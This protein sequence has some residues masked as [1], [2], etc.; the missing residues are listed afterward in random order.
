MPLVDNIVSNIMY[1]N[2]VNAV[3]KLQGFALNKEQLDNID[4]ILKAITKNGVKRKR[5]IAYIFATIFHESARK[6]I[7]NGKKV[8]RRIVCVEEIGKGKG[9][10][11]G[12]K[13]K[14]SGE[15]YTTPDKLYYGRGF[16]QLTWY[17]LYALFGKKIGIDL[18]ANPDLAL[19]PNVASEIAV[20]GMRDGLFT[21]V[22][23]EKYFNDTKTDPINARKIINSLDN[24]KNIE[25]YYKFIISSL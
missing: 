4:I 9:K 15:T 16:I 3:T 13:V 21:G 17:E 18:L 10:R 6:E 12:K 22:S 25:K 23:L 7:I 1:D 5:Q 2:I 24:A 11:Y 20:L 14:Y 8:Y 19:Q